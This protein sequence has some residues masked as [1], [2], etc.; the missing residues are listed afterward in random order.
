M[1]LL[2]IEEQETVYKRLNNYYIGGNEKKGIDL[3]YPIYINEKSAMLNLSEDT[4]LITKNFET[5]EGYPNFTLVE[6]K[7]Y[8]SYDLTRA[9]GNEY[10]FIETPEKT[11]ITGKDIKIVT[12]K[13][14]YEIPTYSILYFTEN[15]I[16]YY[17]IEG[18][19]LIY[20]NIL[21]IDKTSQIT[22]QKVTEENNIEISYEELLLKLGIMQEEVNI[23][24]EQEKEENVVNTNITEESQEPVQGENTTEEN[25]YL[26]PTITAS[27]FE[28][29][30]YTARTNIEIQDEQGRILGA[31]FIIRRNNRIYQRRQ[32]TGAGSLELTSLVPDTEFEVEGTYIYLNENNNQIEETFYQGEFTTK[33][34]DTLGSINIQ[35]EPGQV[36]SNKIEIKNFYIENEATDEVIKGISKIEVEIEGI[37]YRLSNEEVANLKNKQTITYQT[38]ET[39]TSNRNITYRIHMY[40]ADGNEFVVENAEGRTRT[41]K[42]TPT[43]RIQLKTQEVGKTEIVLNLNNKD[44]VKLENYHYI[45]TNARGE[46]IRASLEQN[47][48]EIERTDLDPNAYYNIKFYADYDLEDGTGRK[49]EQ[50][51]LDTNFTTMPLASLGQVFWNTEAKDI[52]QHEATLSIQI[53]EI[54]TDKRLI[55]IINKA[56]VKITDETGK[57]FDTYELDVNQIKANEVMTINLQGLNS[58]TEYTYEII[59]TVKQ[60]SVEENIGKEQTQSSFITRKKPAEVIIKNQFV[61]GELIDFDVAVQDEDGSI[62]LDYVRMEIRDEKSNL[63]SVENITKNQEDIRK[64]Y[65][66][67]EPN[68]NYTITFIAEQYNEG[69][70]NSTYQANYI[71]ETRTIY[72]EISI[73]GE[74]E[75]HSLSKKGTGKNL[76]NVE[77]EV[78]WIGPIWG[79]SIDEEYTKQYDKENGILKLGN[80]ASSIATYVYDLREYIG[81]EVTISFEAIL[82]GD[83]SNYNVGIQNSKNATNR[84]KIENLST[85]EY[86]EYQYTVTIDE[87][88]YLGFYTSPKQGIMLKNVQVELGNRKSSY[89]PFTYERE[90]EVGVSLEDRKGEITTKDYY[91]RVYENDSLI[92]EERYEELGEEGRVEDVI[93]KF[94]N[95][96]PGN[97]YKL[98]LIV[99]IRERYYIIDDL[100]I[101]VEED[102]EIKAIRN[103]EEYREIQPYGQYVV[104]NDLDMTS[105]KMS[106]IYS[107]AGEI[108][109]N[110]HTV[111]RDVTSSTNGLFYTIRPTGVIKNLVVEMHL[112]N[113]NALSGL[114]GVFVYNYGT[115]RNIQLNITETT[116]KENSNLSPLGYINFQGGIVENFVIHLEEALY[117]NNNLTACVFYNRGIIQNGYI[118]GK[119]IEAIYPLSSGQTREVGVV[120]FYNTGTGSIKNVYSLVSV[121]TIHQEE[122][123]EHF[124]NI[125]CI[126]NGG[127]NIQN[128]YSVGIGNTNDLNNG[129]NVYYAGSTNIENNYYFCDEIFNNEYHTKT[130]ML[131]LRDVNFQNQLLNTNDGF[132]VDELVRNGYYPHVKMPDVM[133]R[134]EYIE[135]PKVEDEDLADILSTEIESQKPNEATILCNVHN[136][137]GEIIT[138]IRVENLTSEILSQEYYDGVSKV[139]IK[140][141]NPKIYVSGYSIMSITTQGAFGNTYTRDFKENE[142]LL[143]IKLYRPIYTVEDWKQI[144]QSPTENYMLMQDLDFINYGQDIVITN[145]G[146]ELNGSEYKIKNIHGIGNLFTKLTG[147]LTNLN[148]ENLTLDQNMNISY[149]GLIGLAENAQIDNVHINQTNI[150]SESSYRRWVGTLAGVNAGSN[151]QNSSVNNATIKVQNASELR[152][153]GFIGNV[154][155]GSVR[156]NYVKN[157]IIELNNV[158]SSIG[159]GGIVGDLRGYARV[160]NCYT[161]G[162]ISVGTK[163]TG[164]IAGY[165]DQGSIEN[166]YSI[167]NIKSET[168][169][170]GGIIGNNIADTSIYQDTV[171]ERNLSIGDI[172]STINSDYINRISGT[173][174]G[175]N[176]YAYAEQK[177]N[178]SISNEPMD[179]ILLTTEE[180]KNQNTY[181]QTLGWTDAYDYTGVENGILPKLYYTDTKELLPYQEDILLEA[182][183]E[184]EIEEIEIQKEQTHVIGR[185]VIN[186]PNQVKI[187]G[188]TIQDMENQITK[189]TWENNKTYLE[190]N[191]T[192]TKYY[193]SYEITKLTYRE[194]GEKKEKEVSSKIDAVFYKEIYT[195]EDWQTIEVGTYQNYRLMADIDFTGK[196][197][198]KTNLTIGRL[199]TDGEKRKLSNIELSLNGSS[200]GFIQNVQNNLENIVFE[201][202]TLIQTNT[203]NTSYFGIILNSIA[204]FNNVDFKNV[205]IE[206]PKTNYVGIISQIQG[207]ELQNLQLEE[208]TI[209]GNQYVGGLVS[210]LTSH[211]IQSA[212]ANEINITASGDYVG[213]LIGRH[214][215]SANIESKVKDITLDNANI[216]GNNYT[217]GIFGYG[218]AGNTTV[219]NSH[220]NGNSQ[221]GGIGGSILHGSGETENSNLLVKNTI[222]EG[223]GVEIRWHRWLYKCE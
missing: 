138:G 212:N 6:G 113:E 197:D 103:L 173:Q 83:E 221:V 204:S 42:Q 94:G 189:Q 134:Q 222:I 12:S 127:A 133:P 74:L 30:V 193:D 182:N 97:T 128:V 33:S 7:M 15:H 93:K 111:I 21:E 49:R 198:I 168:D 207:G 90:L 167:V 27:N 48:K 154:T 51:L 223:K 145:Y 149:I 55:Q 152:A 20:H 22:I 203:G 62:L 79:A 101:E 153:G 37:R 190:F 72:T 184:L 162:D 5:V 139:R 112:N 202:I 46:E 160:E 157:L 53:D 85:N 130:T 209:T 26:K 1:N 28:A 175:E 86:K 172:Y 205:T 68:K 165:V 4:K 59:T 67:L 143:S 117:G 84:T 179:A 8:N 156:N 166:C 76:I 123:Y 87:T 92:Q 54:K 13:T 80:H 115:I 109:F 180:L 219:L 121:N 45:I 220:I 64:Q 137:S 183:K 24:P 159:V 148:I 2:K 210:Y 106:I 151:I 119:N 215:I 122:V 10:I 3:N 89:E 57:E 170:M 39:V 131:A 163:N 120:S 44:N 136:P 158:Q 82:I 88:G 56:E 52:G 216:T 135:L 144:N 108:D 142:R 110:G 58:N 95:I 81:K 98:E 36:Y 214:E 69:R 11:Y 29:G 195:Y 199:E 174:V 77:S 105:N 186:N 150:Q 191:A 178:G 60:G 140:L 218:K 206:A 102:T 16:T 211:E 25:E 99:K 73:T 126:N 78:N 96:K 116:Q 194:N 196:N 161:H 177:I 17:T 38:N 35:H 201:N 91:I 14:E 185:L 61:T 181:T 41:S 187:E 18:E 9:D 118:Y 47:E 141:S 23:L 171:R 125:S 19:K 124:G 192:P 146:G 104:V 217:G 155:G 176:N 31:T 100:E 188:I 70:D 50:L 164:G 75:L 32:I 114:Y 43:L 107:F 129:P 200:Q 40:D 71:L 65:D 147:T 132:E 213:G 208:I 169:Y 34:I 66:R 63:I